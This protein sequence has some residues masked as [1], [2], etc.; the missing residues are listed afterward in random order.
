M[1]NNTIS[2]PTLTIWMSAY[3]G[4]NWDR[5]SCGMVKIT[6]ARDED[7]AR[8]ISS[9][10]HLVLVEDE[11]DNNPWDAFPM[12]SAALYPLCEHGMLLQS[13]YGPTHFMDYDTERQMAGY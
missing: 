2:R 1:S 4:W 13:C 11:D 6:F 10:L 7:A 12:A 8:Y 5:T 9:H 3:G